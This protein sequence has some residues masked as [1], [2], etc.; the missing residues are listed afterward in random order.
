MNVL[1]IL[2]RHLSSNAAPTFLRRGAQPLGC[3]GSSRKPSAICLV[4]PR[5]AVLDI[6]FP[7]VDFCL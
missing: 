1:L 7:H 6:V 5:W 4:L 3:S 2:F